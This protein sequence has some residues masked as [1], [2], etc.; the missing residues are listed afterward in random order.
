VIIVPSRNGG[1]TAG[2]LVGTVVGAIAGTL[3]IIAIA[4]LLVL[5]R[6][7]AR[8]HVPVSVYP[9]HNVVH[10]N[11]QIYNSL[12]YGAPSQSVVQEA[13]GRQSGT[14]ELAVVRG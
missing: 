5:R 1:L 6:R 10:E 13:G 7:R 11:G 8:G 9:G 12:S 2:E 3:A 14:P 4:L